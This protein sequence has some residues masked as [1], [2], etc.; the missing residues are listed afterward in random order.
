M[1]YFGL[2]GLTYKYYGQ[3]YQIEL[4]ISERLYNLVE[5]ELPALN[6]SPVN[7]DVLQQSDFLR[8]SEPCCLHRR[9]WNKQKGCQTN[10]DR[11]T[12]ERNEHDSPP[13]EPCLGCYMLETIGDG[14][15]NNLAK[16]KPTIPE[17]EPRCLLR[18]GTP[19]RTDEKE[20]RT[21]SCFKYTKEDTRD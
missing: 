9:V 1:E 17:R 7:A 8:V 6:G 11:H 16:P 20:G 2:G 18:L 12:A 4:W 13:S 3:N 15:S 21:D 14:A 5:L 10:D 19:L